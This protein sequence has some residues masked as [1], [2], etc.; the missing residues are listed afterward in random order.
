LFLAN[1]GLVVHMSGSV[2]LGCTAYLLYFLIFNRR[3][4]AEIKGMLRR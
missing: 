4:F 3:M 2:A 1:H